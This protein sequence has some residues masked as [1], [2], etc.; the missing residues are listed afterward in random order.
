[1]PTSNERDYQADF[2]VGIKQWARDDR[3][4]EKLLSKSQRALTDTELLAIVI[5]SGTAR[6][7]AVELSR[8][9][10]NSVSNNLSELARLDLPA[11]LRFKGI[12]TAKASNIMA[13]MELARRRR[14]SEG[15]QK[16]AIG[17]SMDAFEIMQP[18]LGDL[19]YE[20]FWVMLLNRGNRI[21]KTVCISEGS[22][23]GTV[24]DPK[25]IFKTALEH[26]ASS[27][28]LCHNHP[29]GQTTPSSND[30]RITSQCSEAGAF[31]DLPVL[32]HMIITSGHY[33]SF[34]DEGML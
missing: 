5:G 17:C 19:P 30:K 14:L 1:M 2:A 16:K 4:R 32:D 31:L 7:S 10:L 28:I 24:A 27:I 6:Q 33:F 8:N 15:L 22:V 34:A 13:V 12:G 3:P 11:L 9:I 20:Q 26:N 21:L 29:S 25:K 18:L 23:S